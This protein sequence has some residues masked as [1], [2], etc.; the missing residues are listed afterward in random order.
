MI[1]LAGIDDLDFLLEHDHGLPREL[2][3]RKIANRQ[4]YFATGS[5]D[6]PVGWLRYGLFWDM[7]P[8]M[9][10]LYILEPH[11]RHGIGRQLVE[12]WE[13]DMRELGYDSVLTSTFSNEEAQHFYRKLGYVDSGV[14][15][16][17]DEPAELILR[18]QIADQVKS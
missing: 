3:E 11:R 16:L 15:L 1:R 7:I 6:E 14:L 9:N 10:M 2:V 12:R 4:V 13:Q 18:K 8:F 5:D 17:P